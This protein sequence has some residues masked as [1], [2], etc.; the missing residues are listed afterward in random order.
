MRKSKSGFTLIELLV[1]VVVIGILAGI[2]LVAYNGTQARSR[3]ARRKTDVAN[4]IKAM[5]L[6]YS[7]N[8]QYPV[9]T[10]ATGSSIDSNWYVSSDNSWTMLN[11][12]LAGA[13]AID[14]LPSDP[15]NTGNPTATGDHAYGVYVSKGG[16]CGAGPGQMYIIVWRYETLQKEQSSAGNCSTN[17]IGDSYFSGGASY[18]RNSRV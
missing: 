9:P 12:L 10:G 1:V 18:Y 4:I 5:E 16:T 8:G 2:T 15:Q 13:E 11:G 17:P 7:D 6:Y 3:D 14:S